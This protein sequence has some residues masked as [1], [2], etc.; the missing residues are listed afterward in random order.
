MRRIGPLATAL[1]SVLV[2]T[3]FHHPDPTTG[4]PPGPDQAVPAFRAPATRVTRVDLGSSWRPGCPVHFSRLRDLAVPYWSYAGTRRVGHLIVHRDVVTEVR[5]VFRRLYDRR[6]P[7]RQIIPVD[8]FGSSDRRSMRANNTSAFNCRYVA[9]TTTWSQHSYGRAIDINP[10]QNPY[11][12]NGVADPPSGQPW[13]DRG[14][15]GPGMIVP[16]NIVRQAFRAQGWGWGGTWTSAKD[17][18]HFS[19]NGR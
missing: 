5:S 18:Q 1:V 10:V 11:V 9:G 6:F 13:V 4:T 12:S 7:I 15:D 2:L 3:A 19:A 14:H 17:Y 8:H 16:H